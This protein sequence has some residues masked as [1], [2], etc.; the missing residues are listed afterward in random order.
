MRV[1]EAAVK[2]MDFGLAKPSEGQ[3]T[4]DGALLGTPSYMSPEQIRGEQLDGRSDLFSLGVVLY[5]LLT[6]E[7]PFAGD[8]ISSIIY[9]IVNEEPRDP[10]VVPRPG[11][12]RRW[13][14]FLIRALAKDPDERFA[15]GAAV[16]GASCAGGG[17][18]R[19]RRGGRAGAG[20]QAP[21]G[22]RRRRPEQRHAGA[23]A[24]AS[25]A[26]FV[27]AWLLAH[28]GRRRRRWRGAG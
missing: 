1:G 5:E 19:R 2:I 24:L 4:Q 28:P 17:R 9:R 26:H 8:S 15:D 22:R 10:A 18:R 21:A 6:G 20:R 7:R 12:R 13:A 23:G 11:A 16:R 14:D 25:A 27:P 3:L